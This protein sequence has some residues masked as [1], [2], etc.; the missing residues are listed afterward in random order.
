L[1]TRPAWWKFGFTPSDAM[2][3]GFGIRV[4]LQEVA[5]RAHEIAR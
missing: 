5:M 3:F 1:L 2:F 4:A